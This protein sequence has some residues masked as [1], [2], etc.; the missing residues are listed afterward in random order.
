MIGGTDQQL[1]LGVGEGPS[2]R[3]ESHAF[4]RF[5]TEAAT[6][7]RDDVDQQLRVL[8]QVEL[9]TGN[10]HRSTVEDTEQYVSVPTMNSPSG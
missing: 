3:Q 5:Q 7:S 10:P 1:V 9:G 6:S 2:S 8:P 4:R